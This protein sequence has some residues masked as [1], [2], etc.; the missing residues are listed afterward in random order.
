MKKRNETEPLLVV[1]FELLPKEAAGEGNQA[2]EKKSE[3]GDDEKKQEG[4]DDDE[5]D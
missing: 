4:G 2:G 5:L 3:V 1:I